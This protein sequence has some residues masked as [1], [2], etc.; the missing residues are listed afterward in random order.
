M[1]TEDEKYAPVFV[2]FER[3]FNHLRGLLWKDSKQLEDPP[4]DGMLSLAVKSEPLD[5]WTRRR[6]IVGISAASLGPGASVVIGGAIGGF[7]GSSLSDPLNRSEERKA[8]RWLVRPEFAMQLAAEDYLVAAR[9]NTVGATNRGQLQPEGEGEI[10][11]EQSYRLHSGGN[12][13][14]LSDNLENLR[15]AIENNDDLAR[16]ILLHRAALDA[17]VLGLGLEADD[18]VQQMD[19]SFV[20]D[21]RAR[22][23]LADSLT[24]VRLNLMPG[25]TL[26]KPSAR[27]MAPLINAWSAPG[28]DVLSGDFEA[29]ANELGIMLNTVIQVRN[30]W[31]IGQVSSSDA[32]SR[33]RAEW[34]L[35]TIE[36]FRILKS[37]DRTSNQAAADFVAS[38]HRIALHARLDHDSDQLRD[39]LRLY[40]DGDESPHSKELG[41]VRDQLK[42]QLRPNTMWMRLF[43]AA[44][45]LEA[46]NTEVSKAEFAIVSGNLSKTKQGTLLVAIPEFGRRLGISREQLEAAHGTFRWPTVNPRLSQRGYYEA[47]LA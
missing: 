17:Q 19:M 21:L 39:I 32:R 42:T 45:A 2:G 20:T 18:A 6:V 9:A 28:I 46:G 1:N 35:E 27:E 3:L 38:L 31:R 10:A 25:S 37:L 11:L 36:A 5:T 33:A 8:A 44:L 7:L 4:E 15:V 23:S 14:L 34:L 13:A 43:R 24:S 12:W 30:L 41:L 16:T 22:A 26:R 47:L 29:I 40:F